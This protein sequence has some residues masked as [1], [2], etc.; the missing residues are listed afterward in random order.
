LAPAD[1]ALRI[2]IAAASL[3]DKDAM[4][5]AVSTRAQFKEHVAYEQWTL[6]AVANVLNEKLK[7]KTVVSMKCDRKDFFAYFNSFDFVC[8][9]AASSRARDRI[10]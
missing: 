8:G 2:R 4:G 1:P 5:A 10:F 6:E 3:D 9:S 7:D